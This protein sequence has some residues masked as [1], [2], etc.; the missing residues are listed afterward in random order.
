MDVVGVSIPLWAF[1]LI[2]IIGIII[3]WKLIKFAI[4]MLIIIVAFLIILFGLDFLGVFD[5]IQN[6]LSVVF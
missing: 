3:T 4:K 5:A 6:F 2:A 1:F